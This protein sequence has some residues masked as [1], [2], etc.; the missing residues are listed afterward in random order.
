MKDF[1]PVIEKRERIKLPIS[2]FN[3]LL[4]LSPHHFVAFHDKEVS[5]ILTE[6][7]KR[8]IFR[9]KS[10][11]VNFSRCSTTEFATTT[12]TMIQTVAAIRT[13]V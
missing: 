11:T 1:G 12:Q 7:N 13:N 10:G 4:A 2:P 5:L 9:L 8:M 6:H 3:K